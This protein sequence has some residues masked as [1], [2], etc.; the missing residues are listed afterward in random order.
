MATTVR[1]INQQTGIIKK[2]FF[3][4]SWT[5]LFF[6]GLPA[7]FRGDFIMGLV[8]IVLQF[9]TWGISGLILAFFY[10]KQY[11]LKLIENGYTFADTEAVNE[12]ASAKLGVISTRRA[13]VIN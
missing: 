1:L 13:P 3:G 12:L 6:G 7:L 4:F 11:T 2:G 5:T 10:N 9:L 8:F